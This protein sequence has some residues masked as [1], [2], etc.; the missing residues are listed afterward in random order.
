MAEELH[1]IRTKV[2]TE[3]ISLIQALEIATGDTQAEI[4]RRWI[5]QAAAAELHKATVICRVLRSEGSARSTQGGAGH[6]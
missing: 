3:T 1:D 6:E 4:V 2:P 5:I